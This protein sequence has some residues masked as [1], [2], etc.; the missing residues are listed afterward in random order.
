MAFLASSTT[1]KH[2]PDGSPK[3]RD[4]LV[5]VHDSRKRKSYMQPI[6]SFK[7]QRGFLSFLEPVM[8]LVSSAFSLF[9]G[10][11]RNR[12]QV[13]SARE[14]MAFQER[15]SNTAHQRQVADLRAAGLNPILSAKY[16][17][18]STPGGAQAA[19]QDAV[20]PAVNTGMAAKRLQA[21]L[22][23]IQAN[24]KVADNQAKNIEA[25]TRLKNSQTTMQG[26]MWHESNARINKIVA[27]T[28]NQKELRHKLIQETENLRK[29]YSNM[30]ITGEQLQLAVKI[31]T[32]QLKG[33][34]IEGKIDSDTMGTVTRYLNRIVPSLNSAKG[35]IR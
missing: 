24:T 4:H 20:T 11:Q 3:G 14:Q 22:K 29:K 1:S 34:E 23:Q 31:M 7:Y 13:A 21:D 30:S 35:L 28:T 26:Q 33:W 25:D 6:K 27:E 8:P 17:G 32:E 15:M 10:R 2:S 16:G 9:G 5:P 18:A 12:Q 19:I